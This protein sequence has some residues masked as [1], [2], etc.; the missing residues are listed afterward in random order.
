MQVDTPDWVRDAVFYQVFPDRFAASDRVPKPGPLEPWDVPPTT[1]G[2]KGGDLL[3]IAEHLPYLEDLGVTALYLNPVF[4][5][6]SN[7]RYHTDD[8]LSVDPLLGGDQALRALLDAAH[9]RGMRVILDGVFNHTGRGFWPFHHIVENGLGSPYIDW[10]HVDHDR[11]R[12]GRPLDPYPHTQEPGHGSLARLGYQAWWDLPALPKLRT[13]TPAVREHLLSV[14]EHWLRFGADGWRLDVPE[15]IADESFWQEFRRRCR[16]V[17]PDAY[18]VGEIWHEARDW[19]RG[20]RFDA[21]MNYPLAQAILGYAAGSHLDRD[22]IRFHGEYRDRVRPLDGPAFA[23]ELERVMGLYDPAVTAVQLD[24]LDSHDTPR[25]VT[26]AG[27]D[28]DSLRVGLLLLASLP[29]A[30]CLYYGDEIGLEGG[31]DPDCRRAFPWD[32]AVWDRGLLGFTTEVLALRRAEPGLREVG[33]SVAVASDGMVVLDR[34]RGGHG[35]LVALNAGDGR[36]TAK[37]PL[38]GSAGAAIASVALP[39][40]R[41]PRVARQVPPDERITLELPARTGAVLRVGRAPTR[42]PD[43]GPARGG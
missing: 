12:A 41:A 31:P 42:P 36:V 39:G 23:A 11:L 40:W 30:P 21:V 19:L 15:E 10:F 16:A 28:R 25:F 24:L 22:V 13:E 38:P 26:M 33:V 9:A 27:G 6:A 35:M 37:V 7:H 3:G 43:G 1:H 18:L 2:F 29:G 4:R 17:R 8:Y 34:R 5:S 20:D 14:A 32:E